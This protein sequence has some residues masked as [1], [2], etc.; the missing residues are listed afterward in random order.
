LLS[1]RASVSILIPPGKQASP[2]N[3]G[4]ETYDSDGVPDGKG[5]SVATHALTA[6]AT[7]FGLAPSAAR[8]PGTGTPGYWK[9][10]P[11]AWPVTQI[12]VGGIVYTKVQAI[13]WLGHVGTDKTAASDA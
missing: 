12:T 2:P 1:A 5:F 13:Y 10:H 11:D 6:S 9:N 8:N 4:S 3:V 7:D